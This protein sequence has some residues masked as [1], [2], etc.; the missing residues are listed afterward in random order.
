MNRD[1]LE[2]Q[3]LLHHQDSAL[4]I[5]VEELAAVWMD[6][7]VDGEHQLAVGVGVLSVDLQDVLPRGRVLR[8]PHLRHRDV[9]QR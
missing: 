4:W 3:L 1:H 5:E 8:D 9:S 7:T 6:A 2:V